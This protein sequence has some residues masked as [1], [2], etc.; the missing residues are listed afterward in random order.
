MFCRRLVPVVRV[1]ARPWHSRGLS[2][3]STVPGEQDN[4]FAPVEF[5]FEDA[6]LG[7]SVATAMRTAGSVGTVEIYRCALSVLTTA[8]FP[9]FQRP[10]AVQQR[11]MPAFLARPRQ[12]C[13][14][15]GAADAAL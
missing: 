5:N 7:D 3:V 4:F 9:G 15:P 6:G 13:L 14:L 10:T 2:T 8:H 12:V 1:S 11:A